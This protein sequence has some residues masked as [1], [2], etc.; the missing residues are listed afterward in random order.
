M[1][2]ESPVGRRI[3]TGR[4]ESSL[5]SQIIFLCLDV[6]CYCFQSFKIVEFINRRDH[7]SVRCHVIIQKLLVVDQAVGL[8]YISDTLYRTVIIL[9]CEIIAL[10]MFVNLTVFQV[11]AVIFPGSKTNRTVYLEQGRCLCLCHF[12]FQ[13]RFIGSGSCGNYVYLYAGLIGVFC[14]QIFPLCSLLG[15]EVQIVNL[16]GFLICRCQCCRNHAHYHGC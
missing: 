13:S 3:K 9:Q 11:I 14:C 12:R 5:D 1:C 15:F 6:I 16:S 4:S 10:Q 8:D 2:L 7:C